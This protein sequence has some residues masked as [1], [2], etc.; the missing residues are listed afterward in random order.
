MIHGYYCASTTFR[1][2][3]LDFKFAGQRPYELRDR[4]DVL[5]RPV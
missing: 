4:R 2:A 3:M 5:K 1:V